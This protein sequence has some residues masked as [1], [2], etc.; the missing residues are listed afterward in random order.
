MAKIILI[1]NKKLRAPF[2]FPKPVIISNRN[3][4][5]SVQLETN[6]LNFS[7]WYTFIYNFCYY[8]KNFYIKQNPLSMVI[9]DF[10]PNLEWLTNLSH[11]CTGNKEQHRGAARASASELAGHLL[12]SAHQPGKGDAVP[13]QDPNWVYWTRTNKGWEGKNKI[14][15]SFSG[16][17]N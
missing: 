6:K 14:L 4:R 7:A 13:D 16:T 10:Q 15:P 5:W 9:I 11:G 8:F 3:P 12:N 17:I 1:T 2:N